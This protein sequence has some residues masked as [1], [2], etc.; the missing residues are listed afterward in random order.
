[1]PS[2]SLATVPGNDDRPKGLMRIIIRED[3]KMILEEFERL[4]KRFD[5]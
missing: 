5:S 2:G 4:L 3:F 1:M